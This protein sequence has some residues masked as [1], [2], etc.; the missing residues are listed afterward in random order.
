M[1]A[2][3]T[4]SYFDRRVAKFTRPTP[5]RK[6]NSPKFSEDWK[7]IRFNPLYDCMPSKGNWKDCMP[8]A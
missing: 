8:S 6:N 3:A 5:N 4:T 7:P 2:L 1:Y